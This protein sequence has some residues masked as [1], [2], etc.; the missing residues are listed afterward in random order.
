MFKIYNDIIFFVINNALW[1]VHFIIN[2]VALY[3]VGYPS[4]SGPV[5]YSCLQ[6]RDTSHCTTLQVCKQG[7]VGGLNQCAQYG[8]HIE[9]KWTLI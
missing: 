3:L 1:A 7:E 5:C 6:Q 4:T 2:S 9:T 8:R